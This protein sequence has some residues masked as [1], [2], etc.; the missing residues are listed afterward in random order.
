MESSKNKKYT[1][2]VIGIVIISLLT[3]VIFNARENYLYTNRDRIILLAYQTDI[4][5]STGEEWAKK[6]AKRFN[7]EF[8]VSCYTLR[9]AGNEDITITDENGW[10]QIVTR[11]AA[12]QGDILFLNNTAYSNM[13]DNGYL[14][15]LDFDGERA[16]KNADGLTCAIDITDMKLD[17]LLNAETSEY[18]GF[19]QPLPIKSTDGKSNVADDGATE[20]RVIAAVYKGSRHVRQASD[21]LLTL[22]TE[23]Q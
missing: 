12:K 16:L 2:L 15:V 20:P 23:A 9:Q 14:E 4:T 11:L 8:E 3:A 17:G 7:T 22:I 19:A 6:L 1:V 21:I 18:V 13:L 10:T 5:G